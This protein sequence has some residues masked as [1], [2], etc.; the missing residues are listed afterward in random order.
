M[1]EHDHLDVLRLFI[2]ITEVQNF[3][4]AAG[5]TGFTPSQASR[6]I[7]RLE[8]RL[9]TRLLERTTRIVRPTEAGLTYAARA[10][11][12]LADLDDAEAE[13]RGTA[14][15]GLIR[16]DVQGTLARRF[17]L[18]Q[19]DRFLAG[20]PGLNL[21]ISETER[22]VDLIREGVDCVLRIGQ[23]RDST[24][25]GRRVALLPEVVVASPAYLQ[26]HGI[27]QV[28]EDL[29]NG[30][31]AVG[32][33]GPDGRDYPFRFRRDGQDLR[34][35]VPSRLSVNAAESYARAAE[36]GL[37]IVQKPRYNAEAALA[38]GRLVEVLA[39][40][41]PDPLPV[42]ILHPP[43]RRMTARVRLFADWMAGLFVDQS[44]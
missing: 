39:G 8:D 12:I 4:Q 30:H 11:M 33:A 18:P 25:V 42:S 43:G 13:V 36:L 2:R 31:V 19:L 21:R 14:A 15:S 1:S 20:N 23:L 28:P 32:F 7:Q 5:E 35:A 9:G 3:R 16:V 22:F 41:A 37:G 6:A 40:F 26:Q 38:E 27:P 24:L 44:G 10:R 17:V 34:I 29:L